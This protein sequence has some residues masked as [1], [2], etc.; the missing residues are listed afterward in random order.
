MKS[1][2][3]FLLMALP[4]LLQAQ[5]PNAG[6]ENW[7][8]IDSIE[9]PMSWST[10]NIEDYISVSKSEDAY[11]GDYAMQLTAN[12]PTIEG[13]WPGIA[14]T[15]M[16]LETPVSNFIVSLMY[17]CLESEPFSFGQCTMKIDFFLEGSFV[18]S[19][20]NSILVEETEYSPMQISSD[21][22]DPI[23][24]DSI[25]ITLTGG[26]LIMPTGQFGN[27]FF[28]VDGLQ[29][30]VLT[31]TQDLENEK[32]RVFPN[33]T[34][35][36]IQIDGLD[37]VGYLSIFDEVGQLLKNQT[38]DPSATQIDLS[39]FPAGVYWF[40][41]REDDAILTKKIIKQ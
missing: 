1:R 31:S 11:E 40:Q 39:L 15:G 8:V 26:S 25:Y 22:N 41:V 5:I 14:E 34:A 38:L 23:L 24:I 37:G 16:A 19:A 7:I 28:L 27:A 20:S 17:K 12:L 21:L 30:E 32:I 18:H 29:L 3:L 4:F 33:P 35:Q 13:P 9:Q 10:N 2:I 6:F 36:L